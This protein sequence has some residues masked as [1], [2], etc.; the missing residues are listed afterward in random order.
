[1]FP[2][3]L[4][5]NG[6]ALGTNTPLSLLG[7]GLDLTVSGGAVANPTTGSTVRNLLVGSNAWLS[8][9]SNLLSNL[10]L[11]V[12]G[13]ANLQPGGGILLDGKGFPAGRGLGFGGPPAKGAGYGGTG[14]AGAGPGGNT[15]GSILQPT[16]AGSGGG[17]DTGAGSFG[18][19][20]G[21]ALRLIVLNSLIL[22]GII[23][24]NG[25]NS[26]GGGGGSG[27]SVWLSAGRF[28]GA[29][30]VS[31]NGGAGDLPSGGGGGGGRIAVYFSTNQFIGTNLAHGGTGASPGGAGTIYTRTNSSP[32][33]QMLVDNGGLPGANTPL[34]APEAFNL[35][36]LGH[37]LVNATT[38]NLLL[39]GLVIDS[40]A[41][42]THLAAQ[43]NLDVIVLGSAVV[44]TNGSISVNG[45]G[46]SGTNGGPG[47]GHMLGGDSDSGSGAGYGGAGGASASGAPGGTT[48]GS[49]TQP[50]DRGSRGGLFQSST[51]SNF[52]QGG[53]AIRLRISQ[54]LTINGLLTANGND[55]FFDRAG[56]GSGG[57][58]WITARTLDG[59]GYV[60]A[61][62]G[63]GDPY[64]GGG[65]GGGRI[66]INT[67]TNHFTGLAIAAGNYGANWGQD[68]TVVIT[69]IPA[70][71]VIAQNP[72]DVVF[73]AVS[74]IDL[75]FSS[76]MNPAT[77]APSDFLLNTP[78]G[79]MNQADQSVTAL[80]M[81]SYRL[82]FP[83][84]DTIGYYE[85]SA[86]PAIEDIYGVTMASPNV[87]SFVIF[88]PTISGHVTDTNGLPV[89]FVTLRA[90]PDLL[91]VVTDI[92]GN[93]LLEVTP[94][95]SGT[96]TPSKGV[97]M[98]VPGSRGYFN[99]GAD[100][101]NQNFVMVSP[102]SLLLSSQPQGSNI[103][104]ACYGITGVTYQMQCSTNLVDWYAYG[105]PVI[106]SNCQLSVSA[107][108]GAAPRQFFRFVTS[109]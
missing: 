7:G 80:D 74:N 49:A 93:Y 39:S 105:S 85:L 62:G 16:D 75:T 33:G 30:M 104:L 37:A 61:N 40:G 55:A 99:I 9:S 82:S 76:L 10:Q 63:A 100:R 5:D 25:S 101:T 94:G 26:L 27:G 45:D 77:V 71:T 44:G 66:A 81:T 22:D 54:A 17:L 42:L 109:Y 18:A 31:A 87:G 12:T 34:S 86:G 106:G 4:V 41:N 91:P 15:Y 59:H 19:S 52:C 108:L 32:V 43:S 96:L 95:W 14:G 29:G 103:N 50:L 89:Q 90:G 3:V 65:G 83:S 64:Q 60:T 68:G 88:P 6:G 11:T 78:D 38:P 24:A 2:L 1:V 13:D 84:L 72:S 67:R 51:Y 47:A 92:H 48:Y 35:N 53:G 36:L 79:L 107:P 21:G 69:N 28:A 23:S 46:F 70:P 57:S 20:G 58:I 102:V 98:F 97:A 73:Y 8:A 56:G